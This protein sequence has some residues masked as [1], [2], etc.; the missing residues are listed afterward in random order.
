M[1]K[2]TIQRFNKMSKISKEKLK[3]KNYYLEVL[4]QVQKIK[5]L[6]QNK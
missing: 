1:N 6:L 5:I 4:T 2:K 3:K